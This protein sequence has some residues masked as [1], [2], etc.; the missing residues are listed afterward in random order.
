[1][2]TGIGSAL[3]GFGIALLILLVLLYFLPFAIANHRGR[4]S[5]GTIFLLNLLL[6]W[7]VLGWL[8][9]LILAWTGENR[10]Q[11]QTRIA[12]LSTMQ[13]QTQA[14]MEMAK[15]KSPTISNVQQFAERPWYYAHTDNSQIGPVPTS[16]LRRM[17]MLK[18][19]SANTLLWSEGMSDWLPLSRCMADLGLG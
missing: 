9:V 1:M 18:H 12:Q 4:D 8:V 5:Q 13:A 2:D 7:T 16:E 15:Q 19:I 6:G 14:M 17:Y 10:D 3:G 11:R